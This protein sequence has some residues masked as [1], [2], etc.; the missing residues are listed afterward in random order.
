MKLINYRW[1]TS[2]H[3]KGIL[4]TRSISGTRKASVIPPASRWR[5]FWS[6]TGLGQTDK[7][8]C[9]IRVKVDA[10]FSI[11]SRGSF[12]CSWCEWCTVRNRAPLPL[13]LPSNLGGRGQRLI[14]TCLLQQPHSSWSMAYVWWD[15]PLSYA[16]QH[17]LSLRYCYLSLYVIAG[18]RVLRSVG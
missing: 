13:L 8:S 11:D 6:V 12:K 14:S 15:L 4:F 9:W 10:L 16:W 7:I 1:I 3:I 2:H 17:D 18:R 5:K